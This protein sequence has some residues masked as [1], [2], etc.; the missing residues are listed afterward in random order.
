MLPC[1]AIGLP[2]ETDGWREQQMEQERLVEQEEGPQTDFQKQRFRTMMQ[3]TQNAIAGM[4]QALDGQYDEHAIHSALSRLRLLELGGMTTSSDNADQAGNT[5]PVFA[6]MMA[7]FD[8]QVRAAVTIQH[9]YRRHRPPPRPYSASSRHSGRSRSTIHSV[10]RSRRVSKH[11]RPTTASRYM[12]AAR[13]R[14]RKMRGS[15]SGDAGLFAGA[16]ARLAS[17]RSRFNTVGGWT[18]KRLSDIG[19]L[20]LLPSFRLPH[21]TDPM[22]R[23]AD[24]CTG[25]PKHGVHAQEQHSSAQGMYTDEDDEDDDGVEKFGMRVPKQGA[26]ASP[27]GMHTQKQRGRASAS[28]TDMHMQEQR[29]NATASPTATHTQEQ[30]GN[31]TPSPTGVH[32]QKHCGSDGAS[33]LSVHMQEPQISHGE[34]L[35]AGKE[36][37]AQDQKV[38]EQSREEYDEHMAAQ[39]SL[40]QM[41]TNILLE[42]V[43]GSQAPGKAAIHWGGV[44]SEHDNDMNR[45][46]GVQRGQ[47]QSGSLPRVSTAHA[48]K[49]LLPS[50]TAKLPQDYVETSSSGGKW[51]ANK[52]EKGGVDAEEGAEAD[53]G[54]D[55]G[56]VEEQRAASDEEEGGGSG[57]KSTA[58][59]RPMKVSVT[60]KGPRRVSMAGGG[61]TRLLLSPLR[62]AT[63]KPMDKARREQEGARRALLECD[64][65]MLDES[66]NGLDK[67]CKGS[68][69]LKYPMKC[70]A[71]ALCH[72][73]Q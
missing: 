35:E 63:F 57:G 48:P 4:E 73:L 68:L 21:D 9:A 70:M 62:F 10:T 38:A 1:E 37:V 67:A 50:P 16:Q 20:E 13:A 60:C 46:E 51:S 11:S 54:G 28:P 31:G 42:P 17:W 69:A 19:K 43:P 34:T 53:C 27:T 44:S 5:Q 36:Q 33:A 47:G 40:P 6:F 56:G 45:R 61:R 71:G 8:R 72:C 22:Q 39:E 14:S 59:G 3:A 49:T 41:D 23:I 30:R 15:N 2:E 18:S 32:K 65:E 55:A 64:F 29:G 66:V 26:T 52:F 58:S 12:D 7:Q 25:A 24:M